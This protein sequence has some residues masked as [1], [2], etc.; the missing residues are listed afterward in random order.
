MTELTLGGGAMTEGV[1]RVGDTVRRPSRRR[2]QLMRDVLL[3]LERVGFDGAPRWLGVDEQGRDVLSWIEGETFA[4]RGQMHPYIGDPQVR[5][6]FTD[7]QV[8]AVM[9][10]LR[11]YHETFGH[12]VICHGDFG[13][14][15]IVWRHGLPFA[16][17]DFDNVYRGDPVDDVAYALRMFVGYGFAAAELRELVRRTRAALEAYGA[18]FDV[19]A[20]LEREYE[21]AE[22]RCRQNGWYRQL[23]KLPIERAWLAANRALFWRGGETGTLL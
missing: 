12:D 20:I 1:V 2:T 18:D 22:G 16:V 6:T 21:R 5:V 7:E 23:E 3:H 14:W 13:P 8:A 4:D 10:L 19:P 9:R 11:R 15:N 17:I